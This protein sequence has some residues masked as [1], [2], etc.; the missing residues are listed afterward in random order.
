MF[1]VHYACLTA[2]FQAPLASAGHLVLIAMIFTAADKAYGASGVAKLVMKKT[3]TIK[4]EHIVL[5][6]ITRMEFINELFQVHDLA[7]QYSPGIHMGPG[8]KLSWTGSL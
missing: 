6:N 2:I 5:D 8:F 7:D 1:Y 4:S 3:K